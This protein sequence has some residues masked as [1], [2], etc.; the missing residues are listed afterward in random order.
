MQRS[1]YARTHTH[2]KTSSWLRS[3]AGVNCLYKAALL[4]EQEIDDAE[5][6]LG[7]STAAAMAK[8]IS[9]ACSRRS[10]CRLTERRRARRSQVVRCCA[11]Q[12]KGLARWHVAARPTG[13]ANEIYLWP[14]RSVRNVCAVMA[15][16][17]GSSSA[18]SK[19]AA[20][21]RRP[22]IGISNAIEPKLRN[23]LTSVCA[24][25]EPTVVAETVAMA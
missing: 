15:A 20:S 2:R 3:R 12:S 22:A 4:E 8:P 5:R 11:T 9:A 24:V 13:P 1:I 6:I 14:V 23:K 16:L 10:L 18:P 25:P 7:A 19:P 21:E 17:S